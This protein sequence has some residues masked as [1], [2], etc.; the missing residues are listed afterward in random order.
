MFSQASAPATQV[1]DEVRGLQHPVIGYFGTVG[2]FVDFDL[3]AYLVESR[4]RWTFLLVGLPLLRR[5]ALALAD[6]TERG[7]GSVGDAAGEFAICV[8][9][10][11]AAGRVGV[12]FV[13]PASWNALLL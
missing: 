1:A 9:V 8:A 2:E 10:V 5:K 13:I 11:G 3:L 12:S 4:P 6:F 7:I